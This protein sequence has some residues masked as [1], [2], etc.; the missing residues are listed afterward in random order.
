[1]EVRLDPQDRPHILV[2]EDDP[3]QRSFLK[4]VL[5]LTG[6]ECDCASTCDEG[7]K[8]FTEGRYACTLI[9]LGL[10]D[11]NGLTLLGQ[12]S[13]RDPSMV[14]II[15]TGE[16]SAETVIDTMRA[17]AFD[18]LTKPVDL[19]TLRA[20]LARALAHHAVVRERS[21]LIALLLEE[22]EQLRA[23]VEAATA[24]IRAYAKACERSNDRLRALLQ[25]TQMSAQFPSHEALMRRVYSQVAKHMPLR[26]VALCDVTRGKLLAVYQEGN[27][28]RFTLTDSD[29]AQIGFDSLLAEAEPQLLM[30]TWLER[31]TTFE[32]GDLTAFVSPRKF[33][34]RSVSAVG[35]YLSPEFKTGEAEQEFLSMCGHFLAFEWEQ[36]RLMLQVAH[37]ASLGN[38]AVEVARNFIQPLT[39]IRTAIDFLGETV[40]SEEATQGVRVVKDSVEQLRRQTQEFRRLSLLREDCVETAQLDKYVDQAFDMLSVAIQNRGVRIEKDLKAD[41]ECVLLNATALERT[42]LDLML[43]VL[44]NVEVGG[45]IRVSLHETDN[46]HVVLEITYSGTGSELLS[47]EA[48][49]MPLLASSF[50]QSK[51]P[52]P[53]LQLAERTVRTCGGT[54]SVEAA[55]DEVTL[56]IVLPRNA[57]DVHVNEATL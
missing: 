53:G 5:V 34:N 42:V 32:V 21:R 2:I 24:D 27:G 35:F 39:A 38:I 14:P 17:G 15:L 29:G 10:P 7:R 1:M 50:T 57:A 51:T 49:T 13:K 19:T 40:D 55:N 6:Y 4:E 12:F 36:G 26:C 33:W 43:G 56:R 8:V 23:R 44:R 31:H 37:H 16:A 45:R 47:P 28:E 9:D 54:L 41:C 11:G 48:G 46:D 20:A 25:L 22:R 18:Y 30:Q 52:H 3:A